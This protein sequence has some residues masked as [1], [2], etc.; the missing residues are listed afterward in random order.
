MTEPVKIK[1]TPNTVSGRTEDQQDVAKLSFANNGIKSS[2]PLFVNEKKVIT[3]NQFLQY[4]EQQGIM[5]VEKV[6]VQKQFLVIGQKALFQ[7]DDFKVGNCSVQA[8]D[9]RFIGN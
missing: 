7:S 8:K 3:E 1:I 2:L 5:R 6:F 9:M 4:D